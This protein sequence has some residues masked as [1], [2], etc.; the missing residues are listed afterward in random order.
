MKQLNDYQQECITPFDLKHV[1]PFIK[2][3]LTQPYNL[4]FIFEQTRKNFFDINEYLKKTQDPPFLLDSQIGTKI[5]E[6][7]KKIV[8]LTDVFNKDISKLSAKEFS[9][10][11][12][13]LE[14]QIVNMQITVNDFLF[15]KKRIENKH[16]PVYLD[17]YQAEE[18]LLKGMIA[19]H[20]FLKTAIYYLVQDDW[21]KYLDNQP[22]H[23]IL[24]YP[25]LVVDVNNEMGFAQNMIDK[26]YQGVYIHYTAFEN[27]SH[28][29]QELS[30]QITLLKSAMAVYYTMIMN[31]HNFNKDFEKHNQLL[32]SNIIIAEKFNECLSLIN[33]NKS[34]I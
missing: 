2:E 1:L 27:F 25:K 19:Y 14:D 26:S 33:K 31:V 24:D 15:Y 11:I 28:L 29:Q 6:Q 18:K 23:L 3:I 34:K 13:K 30:N 10:I 21:Q 32:N 20:H 8:S 4:T 7:L 12:K 16:A 5:N 22:T 9:D 17:L